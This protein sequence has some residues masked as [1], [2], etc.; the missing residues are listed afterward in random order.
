ML[1]SLRPRLL[2]AL[3]MVIILA[4]AAVALFGSRMTTSEFQRY[5]NSESVSRGRSMAELMIYYRQNRTW[6]NVQPLLE[7]MAQISG[8]R[9]ILADKSGRIIADSARELIGAVVADPVETNPNR[10]LSDLAESQTS[11]PVDQLLGRPAVLIT[12]PDIP[13]VYVYITSPA[14]GSGA[15]FLGSV[16]RQL[17]AAVLAAGLISL[18]LTTFFSRRILYPVEVLTKA[19]RIMEKGDLSQ[20]VQVTTRDEIG[21]LAQAF[22]A[23]AD[24]LERQ[25]TLRRHMVG[26]IAHELRTPLSN[27]RGYLE[28]LRDD[29]ILPTPALITSLHQEAILLNNLVNDLQDLALSEAG[30]LQLQCEPVAIDALIERAIESLQPQADEKQIDI[31]THMPPDLPLVAVDHRRVHQILRNLLA[32]A[33]AY[34]PAHGRV[35]VAAQADAAMVT[36]KVS[37]SGIGIAPE[38]LPNIFERFYRADASR[39]RATG[40]TGLGL[41][42]SRQL[43]EAHGGNIHIESKVNRGTEV[44]FTLPIADLPSPEIRP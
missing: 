36:V 44:S 6:E 35:Q 38:H 4:L 41:A 3:F 31:S 14:T 2:L 33:V 21:E 34:T 7:Q 18:L 39:A 22:N 11:T 9:I 12:S 10:A 24:G 30:Q 15:F 16:N 43:V 27:I 26:D 32:N 37:D 13:N 5:I 8:D 17:L 29:V 42:I 1:H 28:A 23:M 19:A 25:E 20:R 40:G